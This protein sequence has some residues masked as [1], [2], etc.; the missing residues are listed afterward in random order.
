MKILKAS[1]G[2]G[3]TYRL[4]NTYIDLLLG[5]REPYPYRHIL[6]VT[7]T[8]K[9]TAEMKARI[10]RDL[11][12]KSVTDPRAERLLVDLLHDYGAFSVSTIDRFFQQALKAFSREIGQFADYQIELDKESL[13]GETMDRI[14]DSLTEDS[15]ELLDW[16]Q[17]ALSD[18]L[19]QGRRFQVD[20]GLLETGKLLKNDEFRA[21]SERL[22]ISGAE[23]FGKDRLRRIREECRALIRDFLARAAA[24]GVEAAPGE[25]LKK[26]GKRALAASEELAALF[27]EPYRHYCTA[28]LLDGLLYQLGLAGEFYKEFDALSS[29]KNVLCLDE[30]NSLLRKIIGGSDAPF[31][32]EK[33]GV[34]YEH[35]LLDEFQDTSHIQWDN[36]LPLLQESESGT[37]GN[38][39]VGDV[40][41]SI[42]RF[43]DSDWQL[44][45]SEV[46]RAF[47]GAGTE[48][49]KGNWRS[50]RTVVGFNNRFFRWA[51]P[52]LGLAELYADVEQ[53]AMRED[54]QDGQVRVSFCDDQLAAILASVQDAHDQGARWGDIAVL[55]RGKKE[56]AAIAAHLIANHIPVIS[57]DSLLLKSS[58]VVRRLVSLLSCFENPDD[59]IGRF[60]ADAMDLT[61]PSE[62][63]SLVDFCEELLRAMHKWDPDSFEGQ[64]LYIQAFMD[65]LQNWVQTNGNKLRYYL[66]HWEEKD[67]YIGLPENAASVRILTIHK[68]KGLEFLHVIFPFAD[69][70]DLYRHE[71]HWCELQ[72]DRTPFS[73]ALQGIYPVDLGSLAES[74]LFEEAVRRE[75][76]LQLVDNTNLFYVA[77][78][79]AGKSLHVIAKVPSKKCR[80]AVAKG[81]AE[82]GNYSELLY[83]FLGGQEEFSAGTPYDFKRMERKDQER[84]ELEF[85]GEY[86]SI[87]LDG[88]LTPS[89][90]ADDFFGDEGLAGIDASPRL[91]GI[92]LH[93][94]LAKVKRPA[95]LEGA[96]ADAVRDG[97]LD[98]AGG[99]KAL[100]LLRTRL[101]AHPDWFPDGQET[102]VSILNEQ[103]LFDT[104]GEEYRPDRVI[105]RGR[106][107]VIVDY[108]FGQEK[109]SYRYQLRRYARLW[110]ELGYEID[111]AYV[112][113]VEE[114]K[115]EQAL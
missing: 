85:K 14:L 106:R 60:L 76:H 94:I 46:Q 78:T 47:P 21:L 61:F 18:A 13:I 19:D 88:R 114:D 20:Q 79:R 27:D 23:A 112:W 24:L 84:K 115:K 64:V 81:R 44:L 38:L 43:R 42:Y 80:E 110:H 67:I 29:E 53:Q 107:A 12:E 89:R 108:K 56:G 51:A 40:K 37:G 25:Q 62:Y 34:R 4:S 104:D 5:S 70:V 48:A 65:D 52:Q 96:V 10:L 35:F 111:G 58:P 8:N 74:S 71:V 39:I 16:I 9:A 109:E 15:G 105:L 33:L 1:A 54:P 55:V 30:S 69:K 98:A 102:G 101:A 103:S 73:P 93:D 97:R 99:Q 95:E 87:D 41:Q 26:P 59:G 57:D 31:V 6:A 49:L 22:G 68:A 113:Y 28:Y 72:T 82:Y 45:G 92:V 86:P 77:L 100:A 2:S 36:F 91:R 66:K 17:S 7:F 32:Y 11:A 75:R 83:C 90:E 3:K 63:H 50:T